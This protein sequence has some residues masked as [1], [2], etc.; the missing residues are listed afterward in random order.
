MP[1]TNKPVVYLVDSSIY[2]FRAW[3]ALNDQPI[4]NTH[5]HPVHA[6]H[7]FL[8][9]VLDLF[10][11]AKPTHVLFAFD[12]ALESSF[13]NDFY[14]AYKA[15]REPA[16]ESLQRQFK[17]CQALLRALGL[18]V[19]VDSRYEA[20]D[21]VGTAAK[22]LRPDVARFVIVSRDKDLSQLLTHNDEQWAFADRKRWGVADVPD[23][24]G[25][26]AEQIPDLLGLMGDSVDNIP[27]VPGIGSKT[28]AALLNIHQDMDELFQNLDQ[29]PFLSIRGAKGVA[30]KLKQHETQ[31]RLCK[32]LATI[33]TDAPL[34]LT[35][36]D[37]AP[38]AMHMDALNGLFDLCQIG[39]L[40]R[41]RCLSIFKQPAP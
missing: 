29:V 28:A 7:G 36:S 19:A 17:L 24:M 14:P 39:P 25:V 10:Q 32:R 4:V 35:M 13:R 34:T 23:R 31:A 33:A 40:S 26:R 20:D 8:R 1:S 11:Q 15:N 6:I 9:F 21:L 18:Q 16:P 2:V 41:K 38:K 30:E 27:G 12:E 3:H 37:L 22:Q 5:G